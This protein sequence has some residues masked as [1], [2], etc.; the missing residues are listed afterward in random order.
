M[1]KIKQ[2]LQWLWSYYSYH[3]SG[4]DYRTW[5]CDTLRQ[6]D[7]T[8]GVW[9]A[10]QRMKHHTGKCRFHDKQPANVHFVRGVKYAKEILE[11]RGDEGK[12]FLAR[13]VQQEKDFDMYSD[14]ERGIES[15]LNGDKK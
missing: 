9:T 1:R 10:C 4:A 12:A 8:S 14:F 11:A 15:V 6:V 5:Q 2:L 13:M 3:F 7:K